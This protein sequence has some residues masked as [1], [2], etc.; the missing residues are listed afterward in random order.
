MNYGDGES[1]KLKA[2][3]KG[4]KGKGGASTDAYG[5]HRYG[6]SGT[7]R[8]VVEVEDV[9]GNKVRKRLKVRAR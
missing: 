3:G 5:R 7:F 2:R 6:R 9:A 1:G 8:V 4:K